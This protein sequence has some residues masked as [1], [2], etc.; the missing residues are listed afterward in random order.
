MGPY[1]LQAVPTGYRSDQ[2]LAKRDGSGTLATMLSLQATGKPTL[3]SPG[4]DGD[5]V[6]L[7]AGKDA[8]LAEDS[9][10]TA[11]TTMECPG[12]THGPLQQDPTWST[13]YSPLAVEQGQSKPLATW[14]NTLQ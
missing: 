7:R 3:P 5:W 9:E 8:R 2:E 13:N 14:P 11:P 4:G 10:G 6:L 1:D 12:T